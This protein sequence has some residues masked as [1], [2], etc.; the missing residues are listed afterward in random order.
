VLRLLCGTDACRR[1]VADEP[2]IASIVPSSALRHFVLTL[3]RAQLS[4]P[5]ARSRTSHARSTLLAQEK[6]AIFAERRNAIQFEDSRNLASH[7][8]IVGDGIWHLERTRHAHAGK[9]DLRYWSIA[10]G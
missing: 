8:A 10:R 4:V 2:G 1:F 5:M 7:H 3:Q 6:A 9:E